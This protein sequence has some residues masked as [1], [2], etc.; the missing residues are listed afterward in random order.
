LPRAKPRRVAFFYALLRDLGNSAAR[1]AC[2]KPARRGERRANAP[3]SR[4]LSEFGA[5][6]GDNDDSRVLFMTEKEQ[7]NRNAG[8]RRDG[9]VSLTTRK[10][11]QSLSQYVKKGSEVY[12]KA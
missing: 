10:R 4:R 5:R 8:T 2:P 11:G 7:M 12:A 6:A 1:S 9:Q 3:R